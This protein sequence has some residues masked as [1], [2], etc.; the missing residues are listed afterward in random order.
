VALFEQLAEERRI[1]VT[2]PQRSGTRIAARMIA[3]DT[4]HRFVDEEEFDFVDDQAWRTVLQD[5]GIVVQCPAMLKPIVDRSDPDLFVVLMR[6]SLDAIHASQDR[7]EWAEYEIYELVRFGLREGD[8]AAI[9]YQ[10]WDSH[11]R[12]PKHLELD[13]ADLAGH[14]AFIAQSERAGFGPHETEIQREE[15]SP[16][17]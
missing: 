7:I 15:S 2:G 14:P 16:T 12:P 5:D 10:Y 9:K 13:Y 11:P 1:V 4:G 3:A 17:A 8:S 6:R